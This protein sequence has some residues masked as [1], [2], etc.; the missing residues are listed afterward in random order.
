MDVRLAAPPQGGILRAQVELG[1]V[2]VLEVVLGAAERE[3]GW[4]L[5]GAEDWAQLE[6]R[7]AAGGAGV[8]LAAVIAARS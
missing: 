3:P 2:G 5:I 7:I 8:D 1:G 4:A 6:P